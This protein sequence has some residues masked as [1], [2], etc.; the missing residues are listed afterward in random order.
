MPG[1]VHFNTL[2]LRSHVLGLVITDRGRAQRNAVS[3]VWPTARTMLCVWQNK[4]QRRVENGALT[5]G[6]PHAQA[7]GE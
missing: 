5:L 3:M 2:V 1:L 7:V 4:K 6:A